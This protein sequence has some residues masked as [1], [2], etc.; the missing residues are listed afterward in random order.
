[1]QTIIIALPLYILLPV[2]IISIV[3]AIVLV[4]LMRDSVP[5]RVDRDSL[6]RFVAA[7]KLRQQELNQEHRSPDG[8]ILGFQQHY[9][10]LT[11]VEA[12]EKLRIENYCKERG[13]DTGE[14][15]ARL[16]M[17]DVRSGPKSVVNDEL[18]LAF[19]PRSD[20]PPPRPKTVEDM[21]KEDAISDENFKRM[22]K[23]WEE[24]RVIKLGEW[25]AL[26]FPLSKQQYDL[27]SQH[28]ERGR[29]TVRYH[30]RLAVEAIRKA[31]DAEIRAKVTG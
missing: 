9:Y 20:K 10:F 11:V 15:L 18:V 12:R 19:G 16:A 2:V 7:S 28:V 26:Y 22:W 31:R 30:G 21:I 25:G 23:E 3:F 27:V 1:M 6:K 4:I 13:I 14:F 24:E 29:L 8:K 5:I 17:D